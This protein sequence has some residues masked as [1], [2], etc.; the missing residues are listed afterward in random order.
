MSSLSGAR[1]GAGYKNP[2]AGAA[3]KQDGSLDVILKSKFCSS[4]NFEN[5]FSSVL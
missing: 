1:A 4:Q 5:C 2:G 3:P